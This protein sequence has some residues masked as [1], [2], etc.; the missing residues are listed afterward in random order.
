MTHTAPLDE[1]AASSA[2]LVQEYDVTGMLV[3]VVAQAT[4]ASRSGTRN[5]TC[6][7][8]L[9]RSDIAPSLQTRSEFS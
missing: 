5:P 2:A 9:I 6:A 8:R 3:K 4:E 7:M 1:L